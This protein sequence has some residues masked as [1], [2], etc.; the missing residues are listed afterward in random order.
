MMIPEYNTS[1]SDWANSLRVD[2][3]SRDTIPLIDDE[4]KWREWGNVVAASPSFAARSAPTTEG[5][6]NW[7]EWGIIIYDTMAR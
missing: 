7:R 4:L 1:I 3:N 5:F 2:F 6:P